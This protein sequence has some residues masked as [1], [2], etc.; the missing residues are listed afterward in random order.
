MWTTLQNEILRAYGFEGAA[1]VR[2][3]LATECGVIR[4]IRAIEMQA[5]RIHVSLRVRGCCPECGVIGVHL[6]RQT[7]LCSRCTEKQHVEEAAAFNAIL[8][9]ELKRM[10]NDPMVAQYKREYV[11][12]RR[13]NSRLC[14]KFG[15]ANKRERK[16][17]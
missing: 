8:K 5:S 7:G 6:N 17:E 4:S 11:R 16:T 13:E 15:L 2:K 10:E 9:S 12:L 3:R 14:C 1:G